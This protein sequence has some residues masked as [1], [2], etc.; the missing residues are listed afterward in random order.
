MT[1]CKFIEK[2]NRRSMV[3]FTLVPTREA[4]YSLFPIIAF[5]SG[6]QNTLLSH[7]DPFSALPLSARKSEN[8][9]PSTKLSRT[10]ESTHCKGKYSEKFD[11]K[12]NFQ[13][14]E[15]ARGTFRSLKQTLK[16]NVG[17]HWGC[18]CNYFIDLF[19]IGK[20]TDCNVFFRASEI[21]LR[22]RIV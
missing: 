14:V 5:F 10:A 7:H 1:T 20:P 11:T 2:Q 22:T 8:I 16:D 9:L 6:I 17:A 4:P 18:N 12:K 13:G 3:Y 15:Q 21:P 19:R